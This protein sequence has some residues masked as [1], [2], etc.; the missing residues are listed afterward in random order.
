[1]TNISEAV[2]K[3]RGTCLQL[4]FTTGK[5]SEAGKYPGMGYTVKCFLVQDKSSTENIH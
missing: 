5:H 4:G 1:M 3:R 2:T